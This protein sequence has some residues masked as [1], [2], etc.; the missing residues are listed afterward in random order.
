MYL[1]LGQNTVVRGRSIVG[2]FDLE[3]TTVSKHTRALLARVQKEN[4]VTAVTYDLP[5]SFVLCADSGGE[6]V[7]I[8][9][10]SPA[11]LRRRAAAFGGLAEVRSADG[12]DAVRD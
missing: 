2:I 5:K 4:R 8:T 6:A 11:T 1:Y 12:E 7:Y 3:N 9:Q 10:M